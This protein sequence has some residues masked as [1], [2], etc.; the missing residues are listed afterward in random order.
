YRANGKIALSD[1][2]FLAR[3]TETPEKSPIKRT[4]C[5]ASTNSAATFVID[6]EY[7]DVLSTGYFLIGPPRHTLYLPFPITAE[8]Y[9]EKRT[10]LAWSKA[11]WERFDEKKFDAEVPAQW[12]AFEAASLKSY[13]EAQQKARL[14][15]RDGKKKEAVEILNSVAAA[16]WR[17]AEK[18][19]GL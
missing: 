4:L 13:G 1:M 11:A 10:S 15:L 2:P 14:F 7:P 16:I 6:R 12:S 5:S 3:D 8:K 19:L 18:T 17:D 9:T